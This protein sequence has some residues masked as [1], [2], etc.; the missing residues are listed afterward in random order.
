MEGQSVDK[1]VAAGD[2]G[3]KD[4]VGLED[5]TGHLLAEEERVRL[6]LILNGGRGRGGE[7]CGMWYAWYVW[8]EV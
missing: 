4:A 6:L 8:C 7:V 1:A 2:Q 3:L 5:M